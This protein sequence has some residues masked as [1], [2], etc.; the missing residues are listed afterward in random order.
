[1]L[2]IGEID[3]FLQANLFPPR[4]FI[5]YYEKIDLIIYFNKTLTIRYIMSEPTQLTTSTSLSMIISILA[6]ITNWYTGWWTQNAIKNFE[7]DNFEL[8]M[9]YDADDE[10]D[11]GQF[12]ILDT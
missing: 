7:E 9:S 5:Y 3:T 8:D 12:I 1:M 11:W 6:S 2:N 4:A 10:E